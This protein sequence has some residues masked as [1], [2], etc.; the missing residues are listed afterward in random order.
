MIPV[1]LPT[2]AGDCF[3]AYAWAPGG[4][5]LILPP[6]GY[7]ALATAR[8]WHVLAGHLA[9]RGV[10]ALRLDLPG[11]GDSAGVIDDGAYIPRWQAAI[12]AALAWLAARHGGAVSVVGYRFGGLLALDALARGAQ[13]ARIAV[14]DPPA[15]GA[16]AAR[17]LAASAALD[18]FGPPPEGAGFRQAHGMPFDAT[19]LADIRALAEGAPQGR[20]G[21]ACLVSPRAEPA[22]Q[23]WLGRCAGTVEVP[24]FPG[25]ADFANRTDV[26][27]RLPM[28]MLLALAGF[29][30]GLPGRAEAP[31]AAG[32]LHLPGGRE[33]G[34]A[35]GPGAGLAGVLALPDAPAPGRPGVVLLATGAAPRV[36]L[37]RGNVLLARTLLRE[38]VASLRFDPASVGDSADNA[39]STGDEDAISRAYAAARVDEALAAAELLRVQ[40]CG[41]LAA[42]GLC[43]GGYIA[44]QAAARDPRIARVASANPQFLAWQ[45]DVRR[46]ALFRR[47]GHDRDPAAPPASGRAP[48]PGLRHLAARAYA[49][50]PAA[51]RQAIRRHGAEERSTR[52]ALA[53][54]AGRGVALSLVFSAGDRGLWRLE[55]ACGQAPR[56]PAGM[57]LVVLPGASHSFDARQ[58]IARWVDL[59]AQHLRPP[60]GVQP[61]RASRPSPMLAEQPT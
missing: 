2:P 52:A 8:A 30:A 17:R 49:R 28:Q 42:A 32:T 9:A 51:L 38:G 15:S 34:I 60:P 40:G 43:S 19:T 4:A 18:G 45:Q 47:P 13:V 55:R 23:A 31:P 46:A 20:A 12:D 57:R 16:D 50:L 25:H 6:F 37:G 41:V 61:N 7:E 5:V 53:A 1:V 54:L 36:G 3:G 24:G 58:E 22:W 33:T 29:F 10:A 11:T 44:I 26:D 48:G 59:A 27:L 56:L 21:R 14:L 35:F 39:A